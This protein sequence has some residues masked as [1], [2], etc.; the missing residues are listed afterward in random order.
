MKNLQTNSF[1]N[2]NHDR[3]KISKNFS[4][5]KRTDR[6]SFNDQRILFTKSS[7]SVLL[8]KQSVAAYEEKSVQNTEKIL[9]DINL[10]K[11]NEDNSNANITDIIKG[12]VN[13][14]FNNFAK[15]SKEEED[16]ILSQQALIKIL[17]YINIL[18]DKKIK[19]FDIDVIL[20]KVCVRATKLNKEQFLD[21]VAHLSYKLDPVSF[22]K[23][24]KETIYNIIQVFFDPFVEFLENQNFSSADDTASLNTSQ[25][26]Q[27]S[28]PNFVEKF[29]I[30]Q[31]MISLITSVYSGI[32]EVYQ[33]YFHFEI[34]DYIIYDK[35]LKESLNSYINFCKD[36]EVYPYLLNM[37]QIVCYWNY[38]NGINS[39]Y[40]NLLIFD[41]KKDLG[42][43]F[44]LNKFIMM[45]IHFSVM[46]FSKINNGSQNL[47]EFGNYILIK[48]S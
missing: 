13:K 17:R 28:I 35:I 24:S 14:I 15:Y 38:I 32:K 16:F 36:F 33:L 8:T 30:D 7:N 3:N 22:L 10:S 40:K 43:V 19:L 29:E 2:I 27:L 41:A 42:K 44:T 47:T 34:N 18:D 20:K 23:N 12:K 48:T 21:F 31:K 9:T 11:I 46:T 1:K 6:S 45:I 25:M 39:S 5:K 37:N 4:Q 26:V